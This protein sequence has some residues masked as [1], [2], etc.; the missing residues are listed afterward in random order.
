MRDRKDSDGKS[1]IKTLLFLFF[2]LSSLLYFAVAQRYAK[3][4]E[5]AK[6]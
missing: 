1:H 2:S 4:I 3:N 6:C 5:L